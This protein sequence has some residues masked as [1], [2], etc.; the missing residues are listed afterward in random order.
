[1]RYCFLLCGMLT[2]LGC[3]GQGMQVR[4]DS[5]ISLATPMT[6][7][8]TTDTPPVRDTG[9][10]GTVA[11]AGARDTCR[12]AKIVVLDVD[13]LLVNTNM[14]G[15]YSAGDNPLSLFREKLDAV[16]ADPCV[17]GVV[18]RIN[19]YGGGVTVS[20][21]MHHELLQFRARTGLP[22]VA[23]L[24]E[25]ATGGAYYLANGA[26]AIYAHPTTVTGGIGVILNLYN[27]Q[28]AMAQV[29]ILTQPIKAGEN[30]DMGS[31]ARPLTQDAKDWLQAM[32]D[33]FHARFQRAVT[34]SRPQAAQGAPPA[35]DG[36][37]F[38][39]TQAKARGLIDEVG[40][41]DDAIR[42][43]Q[44]RSGRSEVQVVMLR[45]PKDPARSPYAT[46]PNDPPLSNL[47]PLSMPGLERS[48]LPTF[49]YLWMPEPTMDRKSGK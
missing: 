40:Y 48:K 29:N 9:P 1:M 23:Y 44:A 34:A 4:T 39:A 8:V 45:R 31:M 33:E 49:L 30:I 15:P 26:E 35:F 12:T 3:R 16:A 11:V 37:V 25:V 41:L 46:S 2:L 17:C 20:D 6:A 28:D 21:T 36:R 47:L 5:R 27:L 32:A 10:L 14:V 22:V 19:S 42:A 38:T 7:N 18:L 13:G 24:L 43:V